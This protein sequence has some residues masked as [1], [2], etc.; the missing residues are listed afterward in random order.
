MTAQGIYRRMAMHKRESQLA[1]FL[2]LL[3]M[4]LFALAGSGCLDMEK[5]TILVV[6]PKDGKEIKAL[7]V[8]QGL[9]VAGSKQNGKMNPADVEHAKDDLAQLVR[10]ETFYLAPSPLLRIY[11]KPGKYDKPKAWDVEAMK[12]LNKHIVLG[13]GVFVTGK[14]GLSFCQPLTVRDP[15]PFL[16]WINKI[17]GEEILDEIKAPAEKKPKRP[18]KRGREGR[19]DPLRNKEAVKLV[20][21]AIKDG[22]RFVRL[23]PG[24]ISFNFPGNPKIFTTLKRDFIEDLVA[25][26]RDEMELMLEKSGGKDKLDVAKLKEEFAKWEKDAKSDLKMIADT[27][28]SIEQRLDRISLVLGWGDNHPFRLALDFS[29]KEKRPPDNKDLITFARTLG[30]PVRKDVRIEDLLDTFQRTQ[31]LQAPR[32]EN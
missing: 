23:E 7:F 19:F 14:E 22:Y 24:R 3:T 2:G 18:P 26:L 20:E 30:S 12:A 25:G 27:P 6:F 31:T 28:W 8:Y 15:E 4:A 10:G 5:Q 9:K 11:L 29:G 1:R 13:K 16:A 17:I 21:Q 32:K